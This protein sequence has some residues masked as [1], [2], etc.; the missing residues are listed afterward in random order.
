MSADT[1]KFIPEVTPRFITL[2]PGVAIFAVH[3]SGRRF[4]V[5]VYPYLD[6]AAEVFLT[7]DARQAKIP[8]HQRLPARR[9]VMLAGAW[10]ETS[11][12]VPIVLVV[13][14]E[15]YASGGDERITLLRR[16]IRHSGWDCKVEVAG[17]VPKKPVKKK[18]KGHP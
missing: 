12:A 18:A 3:A 11:P 6:V 13:P 15:L 9:R 1:D 16:Y 14:A 4:P 10:G 5:R 17:A 7:R 8:D 2:P